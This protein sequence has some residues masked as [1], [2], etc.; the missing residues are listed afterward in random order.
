MTKR[1]L[2]IVMLGLLA[3]GCASTQRDANFVPLGSYSSISVS[4]DAK[5]FLAKIADDP[6]YDGYVKSCQDANDVV[7][8]GVSNWISEKFVGSGSKALKLRASISEFKSG[9]GAARFFLG[10]AANGYIVY[11]V[12]F[13]D[14]TN[15]IYD[16]FIRADISAN[17]LPGMEKLDAY[18]MIARKINN[19]IKNHM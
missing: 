13:L 14:G 6:H 11:H 12:Q 1:I 3:A 2:G 15:A 10:N 16:E 4:T 19:F 7:A 18:R 17:S 5:D 8:K 9:S